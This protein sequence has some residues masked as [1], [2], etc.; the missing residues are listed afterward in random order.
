M[1]YALVLHGANEWKHAPFIARHLGK[2][3]WIMTAWCCV[4]H[5]A[6]ASWWIEQEMGRKEGKYYFGR[7]AA[8]TTELGFWSAGVSQAYLSAASLGQLVIRQHTGGVSWGI[9]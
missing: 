3:F 7:V 8:D 6:S 1:V 5:W 9:W 2:V 4:G